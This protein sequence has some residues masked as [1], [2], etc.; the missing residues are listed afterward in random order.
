MSSSPSLSTSFSNSYSYSYQF[1]YLILTFISSF[2][3]I[4]LCFVCLSLDCRSAALQ[5]L[6]LEQ[7]VL[8]HNP[9]LSFNESRETREVPP[10]KPHRQCG[11]LSYTHQRTRPTKPVHSL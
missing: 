5:C 4:Y 2:I 6:C 11:A 1:D 10:P 8:G 9:A 3:I 7:V